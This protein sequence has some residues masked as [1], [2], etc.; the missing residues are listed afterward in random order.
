MDLAIAQ[1]SIMP[2]AHDNGVICCS[3]FVMATT[4]KYNSNE[5]ILFDDSNINQ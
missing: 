3:F 4:I 1:S 5:N 2:I